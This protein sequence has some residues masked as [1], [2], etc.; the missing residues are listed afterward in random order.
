MFERS[1]ARRLTV[2]VLVAGAFAAAPGAAHAKKQPSCASKGSTTILRTGKVRVFEVGKVNRTVYACLLRNGKKLEV[3]QY[4]SCGCS[5]ADEPQPVIWVAREAVAVNDSEC[6]PQGQGC[7]GTVASFDV[8]DRARKYRED[9]PTGVISDLVLKP[10]ASFAYI[11][12]DT[13]R[14]ADSA[15][16]GELDAGPD[17]R[18]GSLARAGST[19]YWTK[20]GQAFSAELQ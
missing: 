4:I 20:A 1:A 14:K 12:A 19:V 18:E 16:I 2:A 11:A 15:G 13:V 17:V 10:N 5:S 7:T 8:R 3:A 6:P 9:V